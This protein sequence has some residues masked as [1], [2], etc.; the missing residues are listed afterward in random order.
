MVCY[1]WDI[2]FVYNWKYLSMY[3]I[4]IWVEIGFDEWIDSEVNV[5]MFNWS[6]YVFLIIW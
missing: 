3:E 4:D 1:I 6:I 2:L 5:F